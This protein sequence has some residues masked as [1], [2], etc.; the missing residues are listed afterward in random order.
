MLGSITGRIDFYI[1]QFYAVEGLEKMNQDIS[2][3][4]N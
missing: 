2:V 1:L 4:S 3:T